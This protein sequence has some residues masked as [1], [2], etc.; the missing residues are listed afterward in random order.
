MSF[1]RIAFIPVGRNVAS[2]YP[3]P[4]QPGELQ[5]LPDHD[6]SRGDGEP[7]DGP[8]RPPDE[9]QR[10]VLRALDLWKV[11]ARR[12]AGA[13]GVLPAD[14]RRGRRAVRPRAVRGGHPEHAPD[15]A[16]HGVQ[17][18]QGDGRGPRE[19]AAGRLRAHP[20][21]HDAVRLRDA[22]GDVA[23]HHGHQRQ[24]HHDRPAEH[25]RGRLHGSLRRPEFSA[26]EPEADPLPGGRRARADHG[27]APVEVRVS[28]GD[29]EPLAADAHR[30]AQ[31]AHLR[32]QLRQQPR[33][34]H[35]RHG[36][37]DAAARLR[38]HGRPRFPDGAVRA[39]RARARGLRAGR[40]QAPRQHHREC[41]AALRDLHARCRSRRSADQLRRGRP[42]IHLRR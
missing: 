13:G 15:D 41:R 20:P 37:G 32:P 6:Q 19:R 35:G 31:H 33:E 30:Y 18:H 34:Q 24:R 4:N 12:A 17:L 28:L 11:Q 38:E 40:F 10:F 23:R 39:H 36:P 5:Q 14:A 29:P 21:L 9:R 1:R 7:G 42:A 22:G 2:I 25:E 16:R 3:E 27:P 26:G 8:R